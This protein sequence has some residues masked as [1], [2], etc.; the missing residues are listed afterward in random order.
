MLQTIQ[1]IQPKI[2]AKPVSIF[3]PELDGRFDPWDH[4]SNGSDYQIKDRFTEQVLKCTSIP[5]SMPAMSILNYSMNP[6]ISDH[7]MIKKFTREWLISDPLDLCRA[8][9]YLTQENMIDDSGKITILGY[10]HHCS[11][12]VTVRR[13]PFF[14]KWVFN[15][16]ELAGHKEPVDLLVKEPKVIPLISRTN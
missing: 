16:L 15:C 5:G 2:K 13:D 3:V 12:A 7:K 10:L 6:P 14:R 1:P 11:R 4:F 9:A 8:S